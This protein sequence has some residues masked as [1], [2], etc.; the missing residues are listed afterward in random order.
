MNE[1]SVAI[2]FAFLMVFVVISVTCIILHFLDK[3][4]KAKAHQKRQDEHNICFTC[5]SCGTGEEGVIRWMVP[6]FKWWS[7]GDKGGF[8][9][10]CLN[11]GY[12]WD[13]V[14]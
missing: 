2:L 11:C 12:V 4:W 9:Y 10:N 13:E 7:L 1:A 8:R 6:E 14:I 3:R 5:K